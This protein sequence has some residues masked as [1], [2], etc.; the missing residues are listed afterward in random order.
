MGPIGCLLM[1]F[2]QIVH[3]SVFIVVQP[4]A[5]IAQLISYL[6]GKDDR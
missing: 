1:L 2:A 3:L 6:S 5:R 4:F